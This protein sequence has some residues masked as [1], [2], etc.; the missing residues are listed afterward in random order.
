ME[1]Q[2]VFCRQ[3]FDN[4]ASKYDRLNH[5]LSFGTDKY[6]RKKALKKH[7]YATAHQRVLDI[8]CGT[9]DMSVAIARQGIEHID[10]IDISE[11]MLHIGQKKIRKY[12]LQDK[13]HLQVGSST[14]I[15]FENQ[16]FDAAV[17]AFG[18]RNFADRARALKEIYRVLK[19]HKELIVLEFSQPQINIFKHI[20]KFYFQRIL[21]FVGGKISGDKSAYTYL[22]D[23]VYRFPQGQALLQELA[24]AGFENLHQKRMSFGIVS[25]YYGIKNGK[26]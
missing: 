1:S 2:D 14:N 21:P 7:L 4:I 10:G 22:P 24:N 11:K 25:A 18:I 17:V 12:G 20:Y 8:A 6:W 16:Y 19:P 23:S 26:I 3:M 15:P 13:I 5:L 9:A